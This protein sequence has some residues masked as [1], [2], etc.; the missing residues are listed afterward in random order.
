M[1]M[2]FLSGVIKLC[3]KIMTMAA[4]LCEYPKNLKYPE[5]CPVSG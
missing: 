3:S 1:S 2:R 4:E 5:M